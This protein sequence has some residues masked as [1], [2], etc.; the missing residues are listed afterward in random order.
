MRRQYAR[1]V[2]LVGIV[3]GVAVI[4][5]VAYVIGSGGGPFG[6]FFGKA[7]RAGRIGGPIGDQPD[8]PDRQFEKPRN[9]NELL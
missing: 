4:L 9:E 8:D 3:F 6:R 7:V 2:G 1:A 5:S